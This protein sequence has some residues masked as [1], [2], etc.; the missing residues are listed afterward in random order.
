MPVGPASFIAVDLGA[1][2]GRVVVGTFD[3]EGFDLVEAHRF[4]NRPVTVD[5][6]LCWDVETLFEETLEGLGKAV[7]ATLGR[8]ANVVGIAVDSWG[9]DYGLMDDSG[10]LVAPVRHY[11]ANT[12]HFV[13]VANVR[14][15]RAEAYARTGIIEMSINTC[16]QLVRDESLGLLERTPTVLLVPDLWTFW[17]TGQRGAERTIAS[18]TGLMDRLTG[19]WAADLL[20]RWRIPVGSLPELASSGTLAGVTTQEVTRRIGA[21]EPINVFRAPA[22]DTASAFAAVV[23]AGDNSGVISCGTWALV[24]SSVAAPVLSDEAMAAGFTNELGAENATLLI[25]NLSGT[26]L[27]D[28]CLR[29]WADA[30]GRS[31]VATLREELLSEASTLPTASTR[32]DPGAPE[33]IESGRMAERIAHQCVARGGPAALTRAQL[34][35]L[36]LDS[37]AESF[38]ETVWAAGRLAGTVPERIHMIGGGSQIGLL[39]ELTQQASGLPV[40]I[41]H[42]EA[43]SVGN[44][45]VQAVAAGLFDDLSAARHAANLTSLAIAPAT[46][47]GIP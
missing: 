33:L 40:V 47:G 25:R 21:P 6:T 23:S 7:E 5:G 13:D 46:E 1:Q 17:L 16:N 38:A 3:A 24:G 44:V 42:R 20:V 26:W 37:L 8:G 2:S 14:V 35:R 31:D 4:A 12:Q 15:P 45:C 36:I 32:I 10:S 39:A 22:H 41:G 30:D 19:E 28:E 18:T 27:L 29:E 9:V 43:T 34:V 11:R